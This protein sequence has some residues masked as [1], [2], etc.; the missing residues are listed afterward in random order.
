MEIRITFKEE[1]QKLY[2]RIF[3]IVNVFRM[4]INVDD[5]IF[6]LQI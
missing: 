3:I 1:E 4:F 2:F 6:S 5:K